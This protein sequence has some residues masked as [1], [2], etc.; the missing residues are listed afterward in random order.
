MGRQLR[1]LHVLVQVYLDHMVLLIVLVL[2]TLLLIVVQYMYS[3]HFVMVV[4]Q[5]AEFYH[6]LL[7]QMVLYS[8]IKHSIAKAAL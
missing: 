5:Y 6:L 3:T 8:I 2:L 1:W 7:H 4:A